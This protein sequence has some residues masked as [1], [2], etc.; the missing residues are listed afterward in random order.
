MKHR[1]LEQSLGSLVLYDLFLILNLDKNP[2]H[3]KRN[4]Y[5]EHNFEK[6]PKHKIKQKS[7]QKVT[8]R[9]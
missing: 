5:H 7:C 1:E 9:K 3:H 4:M 2:A 6:V 8:Y